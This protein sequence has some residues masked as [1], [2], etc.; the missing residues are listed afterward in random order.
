MDVAPVYL[1]DVAV[2]AAAA[3]AMTGGSASN[4]AIP[5]IDIKL[6]WVR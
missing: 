6:I 1:A 5:C 4:L 2:H 3:V